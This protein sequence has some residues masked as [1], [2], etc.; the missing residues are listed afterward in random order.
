VLFN[1]INNA[2]KFTR[3]RSDGRVEVDGTSSNGT[4]VTVCVRDNGVGFDAARR[5]LLF[6]PFSRLHGA[7][8]E[9]CGIG[10][11]IV[12]HAVERHGGHVWA[13]GAP[14]QGASF[15]FTLPLARG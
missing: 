15:Y 3:Q 13:D 7:R 12:R 2:V 9:G 14:G 6:K 1:L 10:L 5:D 8:Y 11:S 4:T